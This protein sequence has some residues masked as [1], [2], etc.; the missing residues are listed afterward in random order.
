MSGTLAIPASAIASVTPSVISA[1]GS[2]LDLNGL[3][4]TTNNRVPIGTVVSLA[5]QADVASFFGASSQEAAL[6]TNYFL[7]FDNSN[8]KPGALL[9]A[10]YPTT[11]VGAWLRG[12]TTS[13]S[14]SALQALTPGV[15]TVSIDGTP[16][17]SGSINLS[18]ATSFSAAAE[19]ISLALAVTGPQTA[20]FTGTIASTVLTVSSVSSGV[21]N[22]G[23]EVRGVGISAGTQIVSFGSGSGGTGTYNVSLS[24]SVSSE[25]MTTNMPT[26]SYDSVT[27]AFYV[28]SPTTGNSSAVGFA[29]GAM[30]AP[31]GLT[32]ATG[33]TL[34]QGSTAA[35]PAAFMTNLANISQNWASF[36]TSFNP[37]A[38]GNANKQLFAAWTNGSGNRYVYVAWDTDASP[39][40]SANATGSL[41][42]ILK[43]SN[44]SG[45]FPIYSPAQGPTL[46][47]FAL[48]IGASIDFSETNGRSTYKFRSQTG[49]SP[50][51]TSQTVYNNLVANGYSCY[52]IFATAN[53]EFTFIADGAVTGPFL[54]MDS[55][56]NQIW[57]N[58]QFQLALMV[59]LT[60]AKSIPYNQVGYSLIRAALIDVINQ[61]LNFGAFRP[62]V[63]LS[64]AQ[65]AEVNNAAGKKVD[66]TL[67]TQG[68]YLQ[69]KDASPQVRAARGSPPCT[70]WYMDGQSVQRINLASVEVQ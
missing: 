44:S 59:L 18:S 56:I 32:S 27:N 10:Q 65:V 55:Y 20:A 15:L 54:W 24:Q 68:W 3:I 45:T 61:G 52:A 2:A 9:F 62:G 31:L 58:N 67:S 35:S 57:L 29:S 37:D 39:T 33:A 21:L 41:G 64:Q 25:T 70:F 50:D 51:V 63:T 17:T 26:V 4:L 12:A 1:G 47:A 11:S 42:N 40:T 53:D 30:A 48:G 22:V 49:I 38:S 19:I 7:G 28:V 6:A 69:V 46:A 16:H 34:S 5:S 8:V 43:T 36:M 23:D 14:L 60:N 66:D 13:L